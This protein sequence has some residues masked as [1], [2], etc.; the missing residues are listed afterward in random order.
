[1]R[2]N[3]INVLVT[4]VLVFF[5]ANMAMVKETSAQGMLCRCHTLLCSASFVNLC[6][7]IWKTDVPLVWLFLN[8]YSAVALV[9]AL[10]NSG[11]SFGLPFFSTVWCSEIGSLWSP[12]APEQYM[13]QW[14]VR[15]PIS[16]HQ[17]RLYFWSKE[18]WVSWLSIK[19]NLEPKPAFPRDLWKCIIKFL[20]TSGTQA[21]TLETSQC[22]CLGSEEI[23]LSTLLFLFTLDGI[24]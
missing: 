2:Q 6:R 10:F 1:M 8:M 23:R 14:R 11:Y 22:Q 12:D 18:L 17:A 9:H 13:H 4:T 15:E 7:G 5:L 24:K 19:S 21:A 3:P 20:G 16:L